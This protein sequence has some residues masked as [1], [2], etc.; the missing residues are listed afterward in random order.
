MP[1]SS[2]TVTLLGTGTS[3]GV[4]VLTCKCSVCRSKNPKNQR[5][6]ASAWVQLGSQSFLIDTS[7]DL[8]QQALRYKIPRV[9]FVLYTHPHSDHILGIDEL[10]AFNFA[11]KSRIPLYGNTWTAQELRQKFAYIFEPKPVE[12]GGIPLL[13]LHTIDPQ[14]DSFNVNGIPIT[15]VAV[16]HGSKECLGYRI[17]DFAY[18]T[19]VSA[20][21]QSATDRLQGLSVLILDCLRLTPHGT[22]FHLEKA[23][24]TVKHLKPLKTYLTHMGHEIDVSKW[25][26]KLPSGVHFAYDGL[27]LKTPAPKVSTRLANRGGFG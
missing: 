15:P 27:R 2:L 21:P 17:G 10:R 14:V 1:P 13:D 11:Q 18:L 24:E 23:L 12:G 5:L 25:E 26:K 16:S 20:I 4:P 22:H 9:D 7:T 19:D 3:T 6:R 8:R